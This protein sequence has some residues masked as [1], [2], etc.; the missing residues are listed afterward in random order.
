[1]IVRRFVSTQPYLVR[2]IF[3]VWCYK[4]SAGDGVDAPLDVPKFSCVFA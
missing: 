1:M 2:P 4:T 3:Q